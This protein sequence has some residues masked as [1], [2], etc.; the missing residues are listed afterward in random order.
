VATGLHCRPVLDTAV[1]TWRWLQQ[2]GLPPQRPDRA[3]HGLPR[4]IE[5]QLLAAHP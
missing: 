3:V 2:E 5:Q 1:D 4:E